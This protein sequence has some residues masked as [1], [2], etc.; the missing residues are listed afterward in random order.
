[1]LQFKSSRNIFFHHPSGFPHSGI[2]QEKNTLNSRKKQ[3]LS[4]ICC[5]LI[6]PLGP[7]LGSVIS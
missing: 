4:D 1:M 2:R 7:S 5:V 6:C 3:Y